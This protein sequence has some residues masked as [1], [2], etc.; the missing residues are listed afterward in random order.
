[1]LAVSHSICFF[2]FSAKTAAAPDGGSAIALFGIALTGIEG[3]RRK[4]R[5]A[6]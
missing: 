5:R 2:S 3:L 1:V 6:T 4:L